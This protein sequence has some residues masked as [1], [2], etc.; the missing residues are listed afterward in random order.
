LKTTFKIAYQF[1]T[2]SI[3]WSSSTLY[4]QKNI[5]AEYQVKAAFLFNFTQFVEW[6]EGT[7][8]SNQT[9]FVIGILGEN[10]FGAY[11][12]EIV[13]G[14]K[15]KGNPLVIEYYENLEAMKTCHILFIN[16]TIKIKPEEI[17]TFLSGKAILTV[18]DMINFLEH[19]GMIRFYKKKDKIELHIN[20]DA[21]NSAKLNISSKL[22]RLSVIT[23]GKKKG[24]DAVI[25]NKTNNK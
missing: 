24:M 6:P 16:K 4:A 25:N 13:A 12:E 23:T 21:V 22:L 9:P 17:I 20:L 8:T 14:E 2:F 7:F 10:P 5:A 15:V 11:L 18:S 3:L 19:G 1:F